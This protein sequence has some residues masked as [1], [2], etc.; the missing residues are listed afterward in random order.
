MGVHFDEPTR[1]TNN[2]CRVKSCWS[3]VIPP[4]AS[5]APTQGLYKW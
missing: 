3:F 5:Q 2:C 1:M 4:E